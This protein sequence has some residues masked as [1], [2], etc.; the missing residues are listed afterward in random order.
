RQIVDELSKKT[1]YKVEFW[2]GNDQQVY[3]LDCDAM[4]FWEAFDRLCQAA[5][6]VLQVGY[7]DDV[8][9][10]NHQDSY[11][12]YVK[13][14]GV[15]RLVANS[16]SFNRHID[17]S[18]L[19]KKTAGSHRSES[20]NFNFTVCVEPKIPLMGLGEPQLTEAVDDEGRS[21]VVARPSGDDIG[22]PWAGGGR[23]MSRYGGGYK[24]DSLQASLNLA[25]ASE[26]SHYGKRI[27]GSVPVTLLAH[28]KPEVVADDILKA[29]GQK[30]QIGTVSFNI[31]DVTEAANKQYQVK[32]G[33]TNNDKD[34]PNDYTWTNSLYYRIELQD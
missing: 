5:G 12:P 24:K 22:G 6:M 32:M 26:K 7:G 9:R 20:L 34:N 33:I 23:V 30:K 19:P 21:M 10:L 16:F 11:V 15:F 2:G 17:F 1:G 31:Q 25:P 3:D 28:Q 13:H 29:K 4:P 14:E 8:L 27:M 18:T